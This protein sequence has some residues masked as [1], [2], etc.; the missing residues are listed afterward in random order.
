M[1]M[2]CGQATGIAH[3]GMAGWESATQEDVQQ[4]ARLRQLPKDTAKQSSIPMRD[5]GAP[6]AGGL[7]RASS[8]VVFIALPPL[9]QT[10]M[11]RNANREVALTLAQ[12]TLQHEIAAHMVDQWKS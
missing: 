12:G 5:S 10:P 3:R 6:A 4:I 8:H 1:L 11:S 2:E 7:H 9:E